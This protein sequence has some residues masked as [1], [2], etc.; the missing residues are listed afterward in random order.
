MEVRKS[1]GWV[2]SDV[3]SGLLIAMLS[4]L[5][6]SLGYLGWLG[7]SWAKEGH[8]KVAMLGIG[9]GL[10][11][12][13]L[14]YLKGRAERT[15]NERA[16]KQY[17]VALFAAGT[18]GFLLCAATCV[19]AVLFTAFMIALLAA[20][21]LEAGSSGDGRE[22]VVRLLEDR[23]VLMI[24][25]TLLGLW[26]LAAGIEFIYRLYSLNSRRGREGAPE[27]HT[28]LP[29]LS[30]SVAWSL[31]MIALGACGLIVGLATLLSLA[32]NNAALF[33]KRMG[34]VL[35]WFDQ[36]R[37]M[38]WALPLCL[39]MLAGMAALHFYRGRRWRD[40]ISPTPSFSDAVQTVALSSL[41]LP[42]IAFVLL[43][44]SV[45]LGGR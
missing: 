29:T 3:G 25:G 10:A 42:L 24:A 39:T 34:E 45:N 13:S 22:L 17:L 8:D 7:Q 5:Y 33:P 16:R 35:A 32:I 36:S 18:V 23:S 19:L 28:R 20:P 14:G 2:K 21:W 40:G 26:A 27:L 15:G 31:F 1:F 43:V 30:L 38:T 37:N 41:A 6:A 44:V 9:A 4:S 12:A 11:L